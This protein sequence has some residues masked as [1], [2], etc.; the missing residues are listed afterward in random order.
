M[1]TGLYYLNSRYYDPELGRFISQ[2]SLEYA[3]PETINGLNLYAY[4]KNDPVNNSDPTG[5]WS[6]KK[7]WTGL[8][9]V[10]TAIAAIAISV[11]TFGAATPLAISIVAGVTLAAGILTGING[12][13]TIVEAG[14]DY[15]FV[16]DGVFQGNETAYNWYSGITEAVATIGTLILG[17]YQMTPSG[18]TVMADNKMARIMRKPERI[19]KY[20]FSEFESVA[21][22]SS[23][24]TG[25]SANGK[26][27]RAF[28]DDKAIRYNL[29]NTRFDSAHFF[30]KP[31][32]VVSSS[33][34]GKIK[35][36]YLFK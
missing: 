4:C 6:W 10:L 36:L 27:F 35:F 11:A 30:G 29:N 13:A 24:N 9:L 15:N 33:V 22:R 21:N 34:L 17:I 23:G 14:T 7:F 25:P 8:G 32:W 2:D 18:K 28:I 19:Q 31:Y 5:A 12:V 16:R 3:D 26:G 1:E 20:T